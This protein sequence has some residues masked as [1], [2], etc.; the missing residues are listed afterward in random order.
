FSTLISIISEAPS[1]PD[2]P[3]ASNSG[4]VFAIFLNKDLTLYPNLEEVSRKILAPW[5]LALASPSC[6]DTCLSSVK[7]FLFPTIQMMTFSPL[8]ILTSSIHLSNSSKD[9][10]DDTS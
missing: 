7:S 9:F 8:S 3:A 10:L 4:N 6:R 5:A 2:F 1:S